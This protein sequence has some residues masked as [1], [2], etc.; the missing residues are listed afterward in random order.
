MEYI[1]IGGGSGHDSGCFLLYGF[2]GVWGVGRKWHLVSMHRVTQIA[3]YGTAND[4]RLCPI[5]SHVRK[6]GDVVW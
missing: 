4:V 2:S 3:G 5:G 6:N 1:A